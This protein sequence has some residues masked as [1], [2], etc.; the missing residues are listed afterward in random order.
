MNGI[1]TAV[2]LIVYFTGKYMYLL[3]IRGA[4][5]QGWEWMGQEKDS[6]HLWIF[7][8]MYFGLKNC[9]S[10]SIVF[11]GKRDNHGN[12]IYLFDGFIKLPFILEVFWG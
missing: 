12:R 6:V 8:W 1:L 3:L 5:G 9:I 10:S 7:D 4:D 2:Y 11:L